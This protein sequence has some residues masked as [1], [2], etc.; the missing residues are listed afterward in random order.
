MQVPT[1]LYDV[2]AYCITPFLSDLRRLEKENQPLMMPPMSVKIVPKDTVN[3]RVRLM[4][5]FEMK[6]DEIAS[7]TADTL[8]IAR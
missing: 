2:S 5:D 3:H 6:D 7:I 8:C 1:A 4:A